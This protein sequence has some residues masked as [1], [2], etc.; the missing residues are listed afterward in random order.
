MDDMRPSLEFTYNS[1]IPDDADLSNGSRWGGG[2]GNPNLKPWRANALDLSVEKYFGREGYLS[3][4]LF[5]KELRSY[6]YNQPQLYDFTDFTVPDNSN[7]QNFLGFVTTP[8]NGTG[9]KIYGYEVA[10]SVPFGNI[11]EALDGFGALASY[12]YTKSNIVDPNIPDRPIPGLSEDV[13]NGTVYYEKFGFSARASVRHRSAFIGEVQGVGADRLLRSARAETLIDAQISYDFKFGNLEGLS[14]ILQG[15]NLT[16]EPFVTTELNNNQLVI[17][18]QTFG[19]R[20]LL[21]VS[22]KY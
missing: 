4:A 9:G 12:S 20:Y 11:A 21:G 15:Y 6:I 13:V 16:D 14:V 3:G 8:Q 2:G 10:F 5:Y 18:H 17:D 1:S 22:V 7:P 19:R